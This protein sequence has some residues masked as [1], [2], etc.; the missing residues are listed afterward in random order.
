MR[1]SAAVVPGFREEAIEGAQ[2][3]DAAVRIVQDL[4]GGQVGGD[5]HGVPTGIERGVDVGGG[6]LVARG[7]QQRAGARNGFAHNR[8]GKSQL[9][10][11]IVGLA[12]DPQHVFRGIVVHLPLRADIVIK[13]DHAGVRLGQHGANF[14]ERPGEIIAVVVERNVRV[15]AG[16]EA[17]VLRV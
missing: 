17:A 8:G 15:L 13:L 1:K 7:E 6:T 12:R 3:E 9:P 2:R 14:L 5:K 16:V 4:R 10:G 11:D